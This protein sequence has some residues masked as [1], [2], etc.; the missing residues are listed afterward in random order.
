MVSELSEASMRG[1]ALL[2][3]E[4]AGKIHRIE[5]FAMPIEKIV[6]PDGSRHAAYQE[7]LE[8]QRQIYKKLFTEG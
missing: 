3:L 7:G 6:E 8:R 4:T 1:A 5:Q 2:V